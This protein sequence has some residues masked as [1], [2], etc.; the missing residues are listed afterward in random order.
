MTFDKKSIATI[1]KRPEHRN[2]DRPTAVLGGPR[3]RP[4]HL[5]EDDADVHVH[6]EAVEEHDGVVVVETLWHDVVSIDGED[7][8][9][10]EQ[11]EVTGVVLRPAGLPDLEEVGILEVPLE[12]YEQPSGQGGGWRVNNKY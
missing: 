3:P 8:D 7:G 2:P 9:A 5:L 6:G 4:A 10:D 12:A 1:Q 11:V